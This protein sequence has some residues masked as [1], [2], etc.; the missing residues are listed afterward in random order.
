MMG[1]ETGVDSELGKGSTFW[2]TARL[3]KVTVTYPAENTKAESSE[4]IIRREFL[5]K[6]VLLVEDDANNR[7]IARIFLEEARL[8]VDLAETGVEAIAKC[9]HAVYDVILMDAQMPELDGVQATEEIRKLAG[10][11]SVP[12]IALTANVFVPNVQRYLAAGMSD[13][14]AKPFDPEILFGT[15]LRWLIRASNEDSE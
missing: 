1:G 14:V 4:D 11:E 2:F 10:W 9:K 7:E 15:L 5:A 6:R 3:G 8:V 12:I 13:C